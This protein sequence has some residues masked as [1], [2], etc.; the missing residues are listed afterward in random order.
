[1]LRPMIEN[2]QN[3]I[4][5]QQGSGLDPFGGVSVSD[6]RQFEAAL[7]DSVRSV[8]FNMA[9]DAQEQIPNNVFASVDALQHINTTLERAQQT[10]QDLQSASGSKG[11]AAIVLL[12]DDRLARLRT[13]WNALGVWGLAPEQLTPQDHFEMDLAWAELRLRLFELQRE[14]MLLAESLSEPEK[15]ELTPIWADLKVQHA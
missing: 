9:R 7:S 12:A 14:C 13:A 4:R 3:N 10:A 5:Q 11:R 2:M 15:T 6:P 1:M 8:A